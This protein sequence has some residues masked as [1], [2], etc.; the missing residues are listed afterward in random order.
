MGW[1]WPAMN[2]AVGTLEPGKDADLVIWNADPLETTSFPTAVF[3]AGQAQPM[4]SRE[5]EL[6]DRYLNPDKAYPPSYR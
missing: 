1:A 3:I 5:T 2:T 4:T 6:R